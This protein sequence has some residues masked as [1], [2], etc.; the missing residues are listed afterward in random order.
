MNCITLFGRDTNTPNKIILVLIHSALIAYI[1]LN[2]YIF[3]RVK[4]DIVR[5]R[6]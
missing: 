2:V 5:T 1:L 6:F 3:T 4:K